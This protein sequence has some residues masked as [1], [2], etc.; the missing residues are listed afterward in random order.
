[1]KKFTK[2]CLVVCLILVCIAALCMG[3]GIAMG[4]G[5]EEVQHM[6]DNGELNVGNWHIGDREFF[7]DSNEEGLEQ[8]EGEKGSV[9]TSFPETEISSLHVDIKYGEVYFI[10]S[11]SDT[12]EIDIDAPK[13]N[14]YKCENNHGTLK[15]KDK[16]SGKWKPGTSDV[17]VTIA[18]PEG[19]A[20]EE[21]KLTTNAGTM[22]LTHE[23]MANEL[24][25]ELDAGE[26][27]AQRLNAEKEFSASVGA[28][29][30]KVEEFTARELDVDCGVGEADL[31]GTVEEK[32]EADCGV[33]QIT[34]A[35]LGKEAD[36]DYEVSCGLGE[37]SINGTSYSSLS[38]EKKINNH[39]G[40]EISLD[41]G[42]GEIDL[43]VE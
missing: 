38:T 16:T 15:I 21:V 18:I 27:T 29:S 35:L 8:S 1:M 30:L 23:F 24:E 41:C 4:S 2:L 17:T 36:Y 6:A 31:R 28:G 39:A 43:T 19:K 37:V 34:L 14:T 33:G 7:W 3:A 26:L 40:R 13:R 42:V 10:D 22:E 5:L 11:A 25:L 32:A 9:N 12:I 20:F